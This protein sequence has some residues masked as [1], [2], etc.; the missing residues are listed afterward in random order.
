MA[1]LGIGSST[2]TFGAMDTFTSTDVF[3]RL[4]TFAVVTGFYSYGSLQL[5]DISDP[6]NPVPVA[7]VQGS[8][9]AF[10]VMNYYTRGVK[11]VE[12]GGKHFALVT[13][14]YSSYQGAG[15]PNGV[16]VIRL[17]PLRSW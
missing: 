5:A 4:T 8:G 16:Q 6:E 11:V 2:S 17:D 7:W 10:W 3:G 14:S 15:Y 13:A 12:V 1:Y 9:S